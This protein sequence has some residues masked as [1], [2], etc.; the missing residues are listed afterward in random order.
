MSSELCVFEW[1]YG[2]DEMRKI[3]SRENFVSKFIQ[4]EKSLL[5][6]LVEAGFVE[7]ECVDEINKCLENI[8]LYKLSEDVYRLE[9]EIGHEIA[10]LT[11]LLGERCGRCG[12][13]IHL[14]AT[15]NDI[16][17]TA[18]T[19]MI[20]DALEI[21]K[22]R[23]RQ[24]FDKMIFYI[25]RYKDLV[26]IG[27]THGQ[28]ALPITLGFKFAN[29]LYELSRSYERICDLEKRV[30]RG[31][32]AGAVGTMAGWRGRGLV[33]E[34]VVMKD[35][36]LEPHMISTQISPRDGFAELVS[37]FSILASQIDRF[38]LE[39]R[40]LSRTEINEIYESVER[41]G[42]S[43]MPHK[44]NPVTAERL[45]GLAR[46]IRSLATAFYENIVLMHERDLS[47]SSFERI[48]IPHIFMTID[49]MFIDMIYLLDHL[50]IN[51]NAIR[52]NLE[53]SRGA[54]MS[55]NIMI[56]LVERGVPRHVAHKKLVELIR[57][58]ERE[59]VDFKEILL[60]DDLVRKHLDS[61]EIDHLLKPESYLGSYRELIDRTIRYA[62][63]I[64]SRC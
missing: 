46:F 54:V 12:G 3:F 32:I 11:Y 49:Q 56:R 31:K 61:E 1:R 36:G 6:G 7:R 20:R 4:V 59:G 55:E 37:T 60:R 40:E 23:F 10:A 35:L 47:N 22:R 24:V 38:A 8:D 52:R 44:R 26:M 13:Y 50:M 29:Y 64:L 34:K 15:S 51:E 39:I 14:G 57:E 5:K 27:R 30:L 2:S 17:D 45:S 53:I 28:H 18:W 19:I 42:S 9:R 43:T 41:V 25:E 33:I 21:I 63:D 62:K 58:A 48:S 16:I